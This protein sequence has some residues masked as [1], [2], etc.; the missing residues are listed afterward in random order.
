M[1]DYLQWAVDVFLAGGVI[2]TWWGIARFGRQNKRQW[3]ELLTEFQAAR[4]LL[5]AET[6]RKDAHTRAFEVLSNPD[7][8]VE[9]MEKSAQATEMRIARRTTLPREDAGAPAKVYRPKLRKRYP[10]SWP[11]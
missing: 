9:E 10:K 1:S 6:S 5:E 2:G 3:D 4:D 7:K 8:I 11:K